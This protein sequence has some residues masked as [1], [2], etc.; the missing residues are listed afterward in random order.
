MTNIEECLSI[1]LDSE[2]IILVKQ[3]TVLEIIGKIFKDKGSP[4]H[5]CGLNHQN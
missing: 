5:P 4:I 3:G 2:T 1:K